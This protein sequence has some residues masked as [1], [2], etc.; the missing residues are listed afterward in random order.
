MD[1][2]HYV[3]KE[4][5]NPD[6]HHGQMEIMSGVCL[7]QVARADRYDMRLS[8]GT[9]STYKHA[10]DIAYYHGKFYV[11]Y[12]CNPKD[13]HSG[14]GY[15]MIVSSD[16]GK[17]F[18]DY[19][20]AFP[21]YRMKPCTVTDYKG[22]VHEFSDKDFAFMHQRRC[23]YRASNDCMILLG[24]YG[25]SPNK[26]TVNW[27]N[28]GI[29]RV[30]RRL[31]PDGRMSDIYFILPNYQAGFTDDLLNYKLYTESDD[32]EFIE[33]CDE[34]L[35]DNLVM[36]SFAEENG[37]RHDKIHVKH[38]E[39]GT[40]QA[41]C[42]YHIDD[43]KVAGLWKHSFVSVSYDGGA[44]F[45]KI[46]KS[47]SLVMSGQK[48]WGEKIGNGKYV[49]VYD[50]TLE[51][52]H[53]YPL[54]AAVSGDGITFDKLRLIHGEVPPRRYEGF[55]KDFGP[56]YMRGIAEN[57]TTCDDRPD[58]KYIY[59]T[60]SVNK[61]D[62]WVAH[63]P[64]D[65]WEKEEGFITYKPYF[66][67]IDYENTNQNALLPD[68]VKIENR[69]PYDYAKVIRTFK[70]SRVVQIGFSVL[71]TK[72]ENKSFY[73]EIIDSKQMPAVMMR[74][75]PD[76]Y[77]QIRTT[78]WQNVCKYD[79]GKI[80]LKADAGSNKTGISVYGKDNKVVTLQYAFYTSVNF[81]RG[82]VFRT[83]ESRRLPDRETDPD[84]FPD[85]KY[86]GLTAGE[87]IEIKDIV[88]DSC[89]SDKMQESID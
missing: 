80:V 43:N 75:N 9:D 30:A 72:S 6:Y 49:L 82:I 1:F 25:C 16:D 3:G 20:I 7:Y 17:T 44:T 81:L 59:V 86:R 68:S 88:I 74:I 2:P 83:G 45:E 13:E 71:T 52:T 24:F 10:P 23:F 48:I 61:E 85:L 65:G 39:G 27:D 77:L 28:Y 41:F 29:G 51:S 73:I 50:P 58:D 36:Q 63:I 18:C 79:G 40:Y 19:K 12:L 54:C 31:F 22:I 26:F 57:I 62:I 21:K 42:Y 14:A 15:S 32:A 46:V 70:E 64:V 53:R 37:D 4:K 38:P 47:P 66:S 33:A 60:Y 11:M 87:A 34:L 5:V 78:A 8:D 69:E 76:G 84:N 35:N 56:Q 67:N 55:W 89:F